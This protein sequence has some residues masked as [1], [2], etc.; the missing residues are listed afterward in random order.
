MS[1]PGGA[2]TPGLGKALGAPRKPLQ[3]RTVVKGPYRFP[4]D[5]VKI[6]NAAPNATRAICEALRAS[7]RDLELEVAIASCRC[8]RSYVIVNDFGVCPAECNREAAEVSDPE[9]MIIPRED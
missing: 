6:L 2:R 4:P 5:V 3:N 1:P 9:I 8:G 7:L